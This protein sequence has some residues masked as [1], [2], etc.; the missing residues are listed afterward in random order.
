MNTT[1]SLLATIA[2]LLFIGVWKL[3]NIDERL[4]D[5]FPTEKEQDHRFAMEDPHG[6]WEAHKH[7]SK[8][9]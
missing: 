4:K 9:K 6:H 5:R 3:W 7:E 2:V 1:D 8:K